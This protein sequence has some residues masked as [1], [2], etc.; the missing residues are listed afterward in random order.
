[1]TTISN[2]TRKWAAAAIGGTGLIHL[3]LAPEYFNEQ[4]YIG[5]LFLGGA[6]ACGYVAVRLWRAKDVARDWLFGAATAIGMFAGFVLSR[7]TGL[8][9]FHESEWEPS[10]LASLALE[11]GFVAAAVSALR[12]PSTVRARRIATNRSAAQA[13]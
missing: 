13:R 3:V 10:G 7:T 12:R 4:P 9:G 2:K 5:V 1:M 11:A 8:P 6:A